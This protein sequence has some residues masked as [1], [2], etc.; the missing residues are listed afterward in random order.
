MTK[1]I[2]LIEDDT[3]TS[4]L[5]VALLERDGFKVTPVLDG[6]EGETRSF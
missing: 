3:E 1:H 5:L 2:L 6:L 4:E